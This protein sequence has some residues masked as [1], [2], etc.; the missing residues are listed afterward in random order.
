MKPNPLLQLQ[1]FGQSVWLDT[2]SR[3]LLTSGELR[4]L[5]EED[6]LRGVTSNPAI[7]EKAIDESHDYDDAIRAFACES[8]SA[9]EIPHSRRSLLRSPGADARATTLPADS[10]RKSEAGQRTRSRREGARAW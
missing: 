9:A 3:H 6:G 10:S 7:F 8:K 1:S 2:L 5:I 4:Q